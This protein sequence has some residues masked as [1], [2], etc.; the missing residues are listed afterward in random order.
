MAV[1]PTYPK[2]IPGAEPAR[3]T[4]PGEPKRAMGFIYKEKPPFQYFNW[5][6]FNFSQWM[7]GLQGAY[8]DIVVG[9]SAQVTANEATNVIA[10]LIDAN[11][12]VGS[13][14]LILDG[15]HVLAAN[16]ALTNTDLMIV[17]ESP[18]AIVDVATFQMLLT[19][20]RQMVAL[21]V[22]N[23]GVEDIQLS[24]AGSHFEG[25]DVDITSVLISGGASARTNGLR[26]GVAPYGYVIHRDA[27]PVSFVNDNFMK[28]LYAT[29]IPGGTIKA[30]NGIRFRFMGK[31]LN[32]TGVTRN[33][34][35]SLVYAGAT[36]ARAG[37]PLP[38]NPAERVLYLNGDI[39]PRGA[40]NAQGGHIRATVYDQVLGSGSIIAEGAQ[41]SRTAAVDSMVDQNLDIRIQMA[42]ADPNLSMGGDYFAVELV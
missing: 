41:G 32:N 5:S 8:F 27:T 28:I 31:V 30:T 39:V 26:G 33:Y 38:S 35:V 29:T 40:T 34:D 2:W 19:G 10:D 20:A 1:K 37:F 18:L 12:P 22:I 24:G 23:A 21:R 7:L 11:V 4:D 3:I 36:I 25:T 15:T 42:I 13:R 6:L 14:V 16:M 17:G 9:S